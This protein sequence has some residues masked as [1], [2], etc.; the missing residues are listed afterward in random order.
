MSEDAQDYKNRLNSYVGDKDPIQVLSLTPELLQQ[1]VRECDASEFNTSEP[2][3]W[4]RAQVLAHLVEGEIVVAYRLR[5]IANN[6][7]VNIQAYDQNEWIKNA[8]YLFRDPNQAMESFQFLR[9]MNLSFINSLPEEAR[10]S[11]GIHAERGKETIKDLLRLIAGHDLNHLKQLKK[12]SSGISE[13]G[14]NR[15]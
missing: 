5:M 8:T 14:R 12:V 15:I 4:S 3:K 13:S 6:P 1:I 11:Y 2:G 9:R 10:N 7:G